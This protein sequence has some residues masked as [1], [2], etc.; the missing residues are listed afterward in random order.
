MQ[1][2]YPRTVSTACE[3]CVNSEY[4]SDIHLHPGTIVNASEDVLDAL[5]NNGT[6]N[7]PPRL[8]QDLVAIVKTVYALVHTSRRQAINELAIK[9][10]GGLQEGE[11]SGR[12]EVE[13]VRGFWTREFSSSSPAGLKWRKLVM[14]AHLETPGIAA[15]TW[16][17]RPYSD[18]SYDKVLDILKEGLAELVCPCS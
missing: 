13:R 14:A 7:E 11:T 5:A 6:V 16:G 18:I 8:Q 4:G 15:S 1:G 3:M 10:A 9:V 2:L 17:M 12:V